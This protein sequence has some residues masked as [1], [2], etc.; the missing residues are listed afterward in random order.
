MFGGKVAKMCVRIFGCVFVGSVMS[1]VSWMQRTMR[2]LV[3]SWVMASSEA[4][5]WMASCVGLVG[6]IHVN[7]D[8]R[9]AIMGS[10]D[11]PKARSV[12]YGECQVSDGATRVSSVFRVWHV[13]RCAVASVCSAGT[14][15]VGGCCEAGLYLLVMLCRR[16]KRK[17]LSSG[18]ESSRVSWVGSMGLASGMLFFCMSVFALVRLFEGR[19]CDLRYSLRLACA[20]FFPMSCFVSDVRG[21]LFLRG[22]VA[23]GV[24]S[25][26]SWVCVVRGAV[27]V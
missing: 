21:G 5:R 22:S 10:G 8:V 23:A 4:F 13:C 17:S 9:K 12:G 26:D 2:A 27:F 11:A 3:V 1:G 14:N 24:I 16:M 25:R 19:V 18:L 15:K 7:A 6:L 20:L